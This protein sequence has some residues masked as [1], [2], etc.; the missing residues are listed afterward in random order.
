MPTCRRC[1]RLRKAG[2]IRRDSRRTLSS[3]CLG[4]FRCRP[5]VKSRTSGTWSRCRFSEDKWVVASQVRPGNRALV[6][7]MAIT[8]LALAD[9]VTP[10]DLDKFAHGRPAARP[11]EPFDRDSTCGYGS[12]EPAVYRHVGSVHAGHDFRDV[13]RRQRQAAEGRQELCTSTSTSTTRPPGSR[14]RT[15]R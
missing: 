5:R 3:R 10:A 4:R 6:H 9:G 7:H 8:E 12:G 15:G 13:R 2:C 14:R 11:F 1:R